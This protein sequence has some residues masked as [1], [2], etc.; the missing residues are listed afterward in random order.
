MGNIEE[1]IKIKESAKERMKNISF[2]Q[3]VTN[4]CAGEGNPR[5]WAYFCEYKVNTR[6]NKFGISHSE[7]L[8]RLTDGK[9]KFW[10]TDID[11]IY[12][13]HIFDEKCR[14]LFEPIWQAEYGS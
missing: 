7:H 3:A 2:G 12:Q 1:R 11:V 13:G 5:K 14:E 9:G 8:A 10:E 6:K 4:V